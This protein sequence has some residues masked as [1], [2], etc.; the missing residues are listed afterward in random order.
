MQP[1]EEFIFQRCWE[2]LI[3]TS[4]YYIP[5]ELKQEL[6]NGLIRLQWT[7][8]SPLTDDQ[9]N[10]LIKTSD[11]DF[12]T[13]LVEVIRKAFTERGINS[14]TTVTNNKTEFTFQTFWST[15][16]QVNRQFQLSCEL[17][18]YEKAIRQAFG[19]PNSKKDRVDTI[20]REKTL[21]KYLSSE[22]L[23]KCFPSAINET[24]DIVKE[25]TT[26]DD[27]LERIIQMWIGYRGIYALG[28]SDYVTVSVKFVADIVPK[29]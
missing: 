18:H 12:P 26:T 13:E 25:M 17:S 11:Y 23:T 3:T 24:W 8:V 29:L 28:L 5:V 21:L 16:Q 19:F 27:Q 2:K 9:F 7:H 6:C 22:Q 20:L 4:H 10:Q 1:T 14:V 15:L